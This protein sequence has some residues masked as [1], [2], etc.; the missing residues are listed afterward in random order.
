MIFIR[1]FPTQKGTQTIMNTSIEI[2][3]KAYLEH[4]HRAYAKVTNSRPY[5]ITDAQLAPLVGAIW[6]RMKAS[7]IKFD[8]EKF[9]KEFV[10]VIESLHANGVRG[11]IQN[12]PGES[13]PQPKPWIDPISGHPLPPPSTPTEKAFLRQ[14]DPEL[15]DHFEVMSKSPYQHVH[16]MRESESRREQALAFKYDAD[17]HETN[18]F[19][20][21]N[22]TD[23]TNF[24]KHH[25]ELVPFYKGEAEHV[26][27]PWSESGAKNLTTI[28]LL[29]TKSPRTHALVKDATRIEGEWR[30]KQR[31]EAKKEIDIATQKLKAL[32]TAAT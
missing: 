32:E 15:L 11:L 7:D 31:L 26:V 21:G 8:V 6:N 29:L 10:E 5:A 24:A 23:H 19:R 2:V 27:L 30:A 28:S 12:R 25:P 3:P 9:D 20:T 17:A 1:D 13:K 22:L 16:E 14:H 4:A 18:P